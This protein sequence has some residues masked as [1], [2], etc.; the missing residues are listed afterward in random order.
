M[1]QANDNHNK[2][3]YDIVVFSMSKLMARL[4]LNT[5]NNNNN[6]NNWQQKGSR[7]RPLK[8]DTTLSQNV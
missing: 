5:N 4:K 7:Y 3:F 2:R 8:L 6:Y 1:A